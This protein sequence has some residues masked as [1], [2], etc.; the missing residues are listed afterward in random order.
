[1]K[2]LLVLFAV[3]ALQSALPCTSA[4]AQSFRPAASASFSGTASSSANASSLGTPAQWAADKSLKL[5]ERMAAATMVRY[6]SLLLYNAKWTYDAALL[7]RSVYE[8]SQRT[9]NP[10]FRAYFTRY[11]DSFILP[12]GRVPKYQK[13]AYNLDLVQPGR[14][15]LILFKATG[16]EKYRKVILDL[17]DQMRGQPRN[18]A[19]GFWHK[20]IYPNQMWLDGLYMAQPFVA[21]YARTF[22]DTAW[23]GEIVRQFSLAYEHTLDP[24]TGLLYHAWD[25][26]REQRWSN[27]LTGQ[28]PHF[29]SRAMGWYMMGLVDVLDHFPAG[30]PGRARLTEILNKVS[31]AL[32]KVRDKESG[33]WYQVTNLGGREGNYLEASGSLMF[34]Y[35]F[36][37]GARLG[38]LDPS[39]RDVAASTFA[40]AV[41]HLIKEN[42]QGI[43]DLYFTCGGCGLGGN[44]YRDG[45]YEYYITEKVVTNDSKGVAPFILTALELDL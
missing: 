41:K 3:L 7:A 19:G 34:A 29:W 8:V 4:S 1:M 32:L 10:A 2:N 5:S 39:F 17:V 28:S 45:S 35:T 44:P 9:G 22:G 15:V 11:M 30:H 38:Y 36:A 40:G 20:Q 14:N 31:V 27:P 26:S 12:D 25:Q 33:L 43:P 16:A 6:D 37:K 24:K 13:Q 18:A 23:F 21:E 42:E